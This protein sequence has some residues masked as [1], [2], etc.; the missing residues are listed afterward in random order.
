MRLNETLAKLEDD[1]IFLGE[2]LYFITILGK[3]SAM[4]PWP[5]GSPKTGQ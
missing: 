1:H 5:Q 2:W 3:P 4:E